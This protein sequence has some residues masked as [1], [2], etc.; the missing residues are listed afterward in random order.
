M[1]RVISDHG[2]KARPGKPGGRRDTNRK[3]KIKQLQDAALGQFLERGIEAVSIDEITKAAGVAKGSF[4]RYFPDKAGL[5]ASL[6][7]PIRDDLEAAFRESGEAIER[8]QTA[9]EMFAAYEIIGTAVGVLLLTKPDHLKLY[10]QECRGPNVGARVPIRNIA[11]LIVTESIKHT[12]R[13]H[14]HGLLRPMRPEVSATTVVGAVERLVF[15]VLSDED[16]GNPL[17][18]PEALISIILDGVRAR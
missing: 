8:A 6:Y 16:V 2:P 9:E 10:L 14:A 7:D 11:A 5:V 1:S 12:K 17:E 13:A 3:E 15:A 4:Y 18:L